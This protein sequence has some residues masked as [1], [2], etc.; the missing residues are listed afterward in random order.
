MMNTFKNQTNNLKKLVLVNAI[1]LQIVACGGGG[2]SDSTPSPTPAPIVVPTPT[3]TPPVVDYTPDKEKLAVAA[4]ASGALYVEPTFKFS[5][6]QQ[7]EIDILVTGNDD[8]P[9]ANRM[10]AVSMINHDIEEY[11]DPRLQDKVLLSY[12]K[13]DSSGRIALVLEMPKSVKK[14]LLELNAMGIENDVI[15]YIDNGAITH[16]FAQQ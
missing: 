3:V 9:V 6:Y 4:D 14:V 13:T 5:T 2:G 7:V 11:D 1:L 10:L 16:H 8:Q 15:A 12:Q